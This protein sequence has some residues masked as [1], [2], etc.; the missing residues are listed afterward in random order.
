MT[1]VEALKI[2]HKIKAFQCR[3][4]SCTQSRAVTQWTMVRSKVKVKER[5]PTLA[6]EER[7]CLTAILN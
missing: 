3:N 2:N 7:S 4:V 5:M 1:K 6:L